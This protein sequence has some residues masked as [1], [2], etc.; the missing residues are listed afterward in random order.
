[1]PTVSRFVIWERPPDFRKT[2]PKLASVLGEVGIESL[3][4]VHGREPSFL[5]RDVSEIE[6]L[7]VSSNLGMLA[8]AWWPPGEATPDCMLDQSVEVLEL[9][10]RSNNCLSNAGIRTIRD[11]LRQ[12]EYDLLHIKNLGR[13][14]LREIREK[15][16]IFQCEGGLPP[17]EIHI[18][19]GWF[20][21]AALLSFEALGI[22]TKTTR[23]L[24]RAEVD[25]VHDLLIRSPSEIQ[26]AFPSDSRAWRKLPAQL[27]CFRLFLG[28]PPPS[29]VT[30]Y[31]QSF[32][33]A[34]R[35]DIES[36]LPALGRTLSAALARSQRSTAAYLEEELEF[37]VREKGR[38]RHLPIIRKLLGW[39]GGTGTTCEAAAREFGLTRE[40]VRQIVRAWISRF[41]GEKAVLL[42][43]AIR[44]IA[45]RA[46][47]MANELEAALV[48][49]G[50]M[51]TPFRLESLWAT[52]CWFDIN[53]GWAVHQWN[54]VRFVAKTTDLEAIRNFHVEARRGISHFGVTNKAYVMAGLPVEA[55]AGFADLCCSL[56]QD[57]HWLDDQHEWFWLPTA[58]NPLEKRLAKVL[59]AVPQVNIEVARAGV[60]RDRHMDGVD[61][62]VEVFRSLCGL[63][64]WCHVEGEIVVAGQKPSPST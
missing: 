41:A 4:R 31:L 25:D 10:A 26:E 9:N 53:P 38:E 55:S 58:R 16:A 33:S 34:F 40:R 8:H 44:F 54:G 43:R 27:A 62:P 48:H 2:P 39:D 64:P 60:L 36:A 59:R 21:L 5:G 47:A 50:I 28:T 19:P 22:P 11:L 49:E 18:E 12:S 23:I 30:A 24:R 52:A 14:S 63:L 20:P 61:L 7:L 46:P 15:L 57:L 29:F 1:M 35:G 17:P 32:R 37:S 51:R 3:D 13:K 42:H 45:R 56:L 6:R